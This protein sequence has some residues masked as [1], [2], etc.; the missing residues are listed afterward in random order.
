MVASCHR[1]TATSLPFRR[2][3][4][5]LL[6]IETEKA[7]P[8]AADIPYSRW[9]DWSRGLSIEIVGTHCLWLQEE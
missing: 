4:K 5:L 7:P 6:S 2:M 1:G 9:H 3:A 8:Q